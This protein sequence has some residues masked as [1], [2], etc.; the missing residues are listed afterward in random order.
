[1]SSLFNPTKEEGV[2]GTEKDV[3]GQNIV[4][5]EEVNIAVTTQGNIF[6]IKK[7]EDKGTYFKEEDVKKEEPF[8]VKS[9]DFKVEEEQL[10]AVKQ[11]E[12]KVKEEKK[13]FTIPDMEEDVLGVKELEEPE[14][15]TISRT[16]P[17][18]GQL[19]PQTSEPDQSFEQSEDL[20]SMR[21]QP[22]KK[23]HQCSQ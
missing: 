13:H 4:V 16:R 21:I 18:A 7:E 15:P 17:D 9:E 19:E 2:C 20:Q 10:H 23:T 5:K 8:E 14:D 22:G 3:F 11:E 12:V 1:M 6:R